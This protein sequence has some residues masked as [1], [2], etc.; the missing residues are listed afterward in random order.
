[1]DYKISI[2]KKSGQ[3]EDWNSEKIIRACSKSADR[4]G[5]VF[6]EDTK[7]EVISFVWN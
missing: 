1:M 6:D 3:L 2:K 4:A 7:H 5:V